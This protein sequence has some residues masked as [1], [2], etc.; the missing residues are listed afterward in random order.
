M[1]KCLIIEDRNALNKLFQKHP[2]KKFKWPSLKDDKQE[3]VNE[4]EKEIERLKAINNEN[5]HAITVL[6]E[7]NASLSLRNAAYTRLRMVEQLGEKRSLSLVDAALFSNTFHDGDDILQNQNSVFLD[8]TEFEALKKTTLPPGSFSDVTRY[9]RPD[10]HSIIVKSHKNESFGSQGL[11][12]VGH[13]HRLLGFTGRHVNI[14]STIGLVRLDNK[15]C[16]ALPFQEGKNLRELML[17]YSEKIP[18]LAA[19]Q[20][21]CMGISSGIGFLFSRGIIH[22]HLVPGNILVNWLT[23]SPVIIGFTFACHADGAKANVEHVLQKFEDQRHFAPELFVHGAKVSFATDVY[24]FGILLNKIM[25]MRRGFR[26]DEVLESRVDF[27]SFMCRRTPA[28]RE[29]HHTL[30][31]RVERMFKKS[32]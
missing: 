5:S 16:H 10:G 24:S 26:M 2:R 20:E 13:E 21:L 29:P 1:M 3:K 18:T 30:P 8:E 11:T 15:V 17:G 14:T 28:L 12:V 22:N 23:G 27:F 25:S 6:R 32:H 31:D 19:F 9:F 4:Q 7:K